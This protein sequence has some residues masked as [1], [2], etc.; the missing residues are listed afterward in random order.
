MMTKGIKLPGTKSITLYD[1][2]AELSDVV[3]QR[4]SAAAK[5]AIAARGEFRIALAGG[6]TPRHCYMSLRKLPVEWGRVHI[7]FG[8]ER[9]LLQGDAQRN[10]TMAHETLLRHVAIPPGNV[11]AMPA[12]R[13]AIVAATEYAGLLKLPLDLVLLGIGEDGHTAS[14]FPGNPAT[15]SDANVVAVFNSP[16]P[17]PER[18]SLG[19]S[20]LNAAREKM[21]LVAGVGKRDTLHRIAQGEPLPAARVIG[22]EWHI[23]HAA[24]PDE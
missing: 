21:I 2:L 24:W 7:Y 17:P 20:V 4:I 15:E 3:A 9:C 10:D 5:A 8:D 13:G 12:E 23:E 18:V 6:E 16:K 1:G 11:H 14:L 22:A 19:M